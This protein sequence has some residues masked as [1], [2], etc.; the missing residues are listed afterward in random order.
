[1]FKID[2]FNVFL[3]VSGVQFIIFLFEFFIELNL[4]GFFLDIELIKV[5]KGRSY[6][7]E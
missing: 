1:M 5:F 3:F 2:N 7:E 6:S 4:R